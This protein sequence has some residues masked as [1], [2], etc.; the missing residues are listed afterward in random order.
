M[1][2]LG[3]INV[4]GKSGALYKFIAYSLDTTFKEHRPAVCV[5]TRRHQVPATGSFKHHPIAIDQTDDLRQF[6]ACNPGPRPSCGANCICVH[7]E[8]DETA[9]MAICNDLR[10]Q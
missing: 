5:V 4:A 6:L 1:P 7:A 8:K 10:K 9:R 2:K 3:A